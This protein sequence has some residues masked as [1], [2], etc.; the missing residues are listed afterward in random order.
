[1]VGD[2]AAHPKTGQVWELP[3]FL[4][5][6]KDAQGRE[7]RALLVN[8]AFPDGPGEYSSKYVF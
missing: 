8:P 5:I 2:V 4:P 1:M 6:G 7:R 3:S